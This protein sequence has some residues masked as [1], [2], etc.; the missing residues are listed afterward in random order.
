MAIV[1]PQYLLD[2]IKAAGLHH[3]V[4]F[5]LIDLTRQALSKL[6]P[7]VL[8][9]LAKSVND[10][11][12]AA[13]S[14]ISSV[15][16]SI[17]DQLGIFYY[18][19]G[20][21]KLTLFG[22][23]GRNGMDISLITDLAQL[24]GMLNELA[25]FAE[26]AQELID[27]LTSYE[28]FKKAQAADVLPMVVGGGED[29]LEVNSREA[30]FAIQTQNINDSVD[31]IQRSNAALD[32]IGSVLAE[33]QKAAQVSEGDG[34]IFRLIFGPPVSKRGLFVL[35]EDGLY[36]DSQTRDYNGKAI[37]TPSDIGFIVG[38]EKW[39]M[40]HAPN[41]GGKGTI[42]SLDIVNK[43]VNTIFDINKVDESVNMQ[44]EYT[45]DAFITLMQ[46][47]KDILIHDT[48]A[49]ILELT[50]SGHPLDSALVYNYQQNIFSINETF[51]KKINKR[52]K[53]IEVALKA[54]DLFGSSEAF[55]TGEIPINDFSYLSSINLDVSID[56][57]KKLV[58]AAGDVEGMVLPLRPKYVRNIG[59]TSKA[60]ASPLLVPPVGIGSI[61]FNPSISS[62]TAPA[63][64]LTDSV[65]T[66][67]LF[68]IYNF[69]KSD[70]QLPGSQ[71]FTT[72]NAATQST[73]GNGQLVG[74]PSELF[75]S[76]LGI[77]YLGGVAK[78]GGQATRYHLAN[79]KGYFRLPAI[80]EFQ[81]M[82]YQPQG[83]SIDCW[84]HLP[85]YGKDG[86]AK[87][88]QNN[89]NPILYANGKWADYNY[90]KIL[91]ANENTGGLL[92][93]DSVSSLV[94]SKGSNTTRGLLIGFTRD[95]TIYADKPIVPGPNTNP[96]KFNDGPIDSSATIASSCFFIAPTLSV[97]SSTVEFV[98]VNGT[99]VS[100]G[101]R[102]MTIKHNRTTEKN[103]SITSVSST[104]AH[105][106]MSFDVAK[107]MCTV[108]LDG[109][110]LGSSAISEVFGVSPY[111]APRVPTFILPKD[112]KDP[113][114]YYSSGTTNSQE[115][116]SDFH[117]G[118]Q[119][120]TYFTPWI[121]GGGWTEGLPVNITTLDGGFMG[122]RHGLTSGLHGH[123]GSVK[124][125][126]RPLN[127]EEVLT[128]YEAQKGFFKNIKI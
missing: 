54:P 103:V 71:S 79:S 55:Q 111:H 50:S 98:P 110:E 4:P 6:S 76:G 121:L 68:A 23:D 101:F 127:T 10:G 62:T 70:S 37:P 106:H 29:P 9:Q 60:F 51:N 45:A 8:G 1:N 49:Q 90:H 38:N 102:K 66:Q 67:D 81:N 85:N 115:K 118:P 39:K 56:E 82:F 26:D 7:G 44:I 125:Y 25:E 40:D 46:G 19:A 2:P 99:C 92:G 58:F 63:L 116:F 84:I 78:L 3:S 42:V 24:G 95:P 75:A 28:D 21:G 117:E 105:L 33:K 77:P 120:D 16:G 86:L 53:Q 48:S 73:Y 59:S 89:R 12:A 83:C 109:F 57:Q 32:R 104:F 14:A 15:L 91:L 11:K 113:S 100:A 128:N 80:P 114:F 65:V 30:Q 27:C 36:Y 18:D 69:L 87:E 61:V 97:D 35:S 112:G 93:V 20:T 88:K 41:L 96:G 122:P 94:D 74:N 43:Y 31:F 34:P 123:V 17:Y 5:C 52:K 107:D 13:R 22:P 72:L 119:T 126:S 47:Q 64:S 124:F 108:Y